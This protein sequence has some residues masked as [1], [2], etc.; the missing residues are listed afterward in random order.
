[1]TFIFIYLWQNKTLYQTQLMTILI[2]YL[3]FPLKIVLL[4][5]Y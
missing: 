4:N 3:I 2:Q 1:M 5:I